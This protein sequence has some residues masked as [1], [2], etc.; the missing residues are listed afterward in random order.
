MIQ[1]WTQETDEAS[2]GRGVKRRARGLMGWGARD[3]HRVHEV[4]RRSG[5]GREGGEGRAQI[6]QCG[7]RGQEE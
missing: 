7:V 1:R 6:E 5:G 4:G 2:G 3:G